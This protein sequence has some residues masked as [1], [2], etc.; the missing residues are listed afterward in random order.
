ME[1]S[2]ASMTNIGKSI[3]ILFFIIFS[4]LLL[5]LYSLFLLPY[6]LIDPDPDHTTGSAQRLQGL[7][8]ILQQTSPLVR[9]SK[10]RLLWKSVSLLARYC[11][12]DHLRAIA[13]RPILNV[14]RISRTYTQTSKTA[15][16]MHNT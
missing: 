4:F 1:I 5:S 7:I 13:H 15:L 10:N 2:I 9:K 12:S 3:L 11:P 14:I 8:I 16:Y 6:A